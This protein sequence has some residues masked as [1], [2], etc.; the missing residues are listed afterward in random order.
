MRYDEVIIV[1]R[2]GKKKKTLTVILV[3]WTKNHK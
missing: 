3:T 1:V 2:K